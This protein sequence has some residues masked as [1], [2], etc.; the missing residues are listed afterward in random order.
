VDT[1]LGAAA[2]AGPA[3]GTF[4]DAPPPDTTPLV[5]GRQSTTTMPVYPSKPGAR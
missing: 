4:V 5:M 3:P 2:Y 1:S